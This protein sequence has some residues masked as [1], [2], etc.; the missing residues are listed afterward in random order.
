MS[1][2]DRDP[3]HS[4]KAFLRGEH[5]AGTSS[6]GSLAGDL[7]EIRER[8]S[9]ARRVDGRVSASEALEALLAAGD[10]PTA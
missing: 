9:R 4:V 2:A 3:V 7:H 8:L 6:A 5:P 10:A 1:N